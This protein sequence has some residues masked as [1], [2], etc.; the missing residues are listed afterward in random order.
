MSQQ[1]PLSFAFN[2]TSTP[3]TPLTLANGFIA[4]VATTLNTLALDPEFRI[5]T[6]HRWQAS[7]Q[8]DLPGGLTAVATYL[9]GKGV[10]LPQSFIPNTYAVGVVNPCPACPTGFVYTTSGGTSL[11]NAGQFELRRRLRAGLQWTA[12]YTLT[13]ATDNASSFSGTGGNIAQ[14]WLD[15]EAERATSSFEQRHQ[16]RF[17]VNYNTG[18]GIGAGVRRGLLGRLV[19]SWAMNA[20]LNSGTGTPRTPVYLVRSVAGVNG[21]VRASLTGLPIDE[22]PEG[23]YANPAAFT[24][25]EPGTWG[26]APRNSIRGPSQFALNAGVSRNFLTGNRFSLSWGIDATNLF[27]TV[28]YSAINTTVG[29]PQFGLPTNVGGMRRISTRMNVGF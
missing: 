17:Q 4:P 14:D 24:A 7:A 5:G 18:T 20:N 12:T 1:P 9:A 27:N 11:Q 15:L 23:F 3:A 29:S 16:F 6:I 10:H 22:A 21:T 13:K 8:R 26:N 28:V 25:P 19:N 2:A